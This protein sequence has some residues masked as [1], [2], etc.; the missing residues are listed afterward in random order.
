[1]AVRAIDHAFLDLVVEWHRELRLHIGMALEAEHRL[2]NLEQLFPILPV[3]NTVATQAAH[4]SFAMAGLLEIRMPPLVAFQALRVHFLRRRLGGVED[5]ARVGAV[6]MRLA[7]PMAVLAGDPVL[8]V[9]LGHLGV[10]IRREPLATSSW[11]VA[12][13]SEP[14]NSDAGA[15]LACPA[16]FAP[17]LGAAMAMAQN[18]I[19]PRMNIQQVRNGG[20]ILP[21]ARPVF[22]TSAYTYA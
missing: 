8:A 11:H 14:A 5:L 17:G 9:H 2:R 22:S 10:R 7:R 1:M 12:Q 15:S 20:R 4:I 13:V 6:R 3:V 21:I 18:T 19:A 16:G